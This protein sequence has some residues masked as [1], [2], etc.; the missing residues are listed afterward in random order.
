MSMAFLKILTGYQN[1][2]K[3][4]EIKDLPFTLKDTFNEF[5]EEIDYP[6]NFFQNDKLY[7]DD[8]FFKIGYFSNDHPIKEIRDLAQVQLRLNHLNDFQTM[9]EEPSDD[10]RLTFEGKHFISSTIAIGIVLND[11][12]NKF[13][14][15][16]LGFETEP[17]LKENKNL[18]SFVK[19]FI[20]TAG[21]KRDEI[22]LKL[23]DL[24]V[25]VKKYL[26]IYAQPVE[27]VIPYENFDEVE[28]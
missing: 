21:L 1:I 24:D 18:N 26:K 7:N 9:I 3:N 14:F 19:S 6:D 10:I 17:I 8:L 23:P 20:F 13:G 15:N 2:K 28:L 16:S 5:F 11:F 22:L 4:I 12:F 27:E 25:F